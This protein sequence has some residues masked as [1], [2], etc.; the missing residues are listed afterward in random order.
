MDFEKMFNKARKTVKKAVKATVKTSSEVIDYGKCK[1]K[2]SSLKDQIEE[3][4]Q[5]I[6]ESIFNK[7]VYDVEFDADALEKLCNEI[8]EWKAEIE[9]LSEALKKEDAEKEG[10]KE[11]DTTTEDFE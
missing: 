1:L 7:N 9:T 11:F 5:K 10:N 3:N 2:I 4:Y 8:V 6:G